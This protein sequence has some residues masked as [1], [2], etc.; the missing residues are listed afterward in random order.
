MPLSL[1]G[2][3][4]L[5]LAAVLVVAGIALA[6]VV[7]WSHIQ[8]L[9]F[10]FHAA[11][12]LHSAQLARSYYVLASDG[13][14]EW[15]KQISRV[16]LRED[17]PIELPIVQYS[18]ATAYR[19]LGG[20]RLWIPRLL[21]SLFWIAGGALIY[22]LATRLAPWWA[23]V[24]AVALYLFLP[25]PLVASTSFQPDPL[26]VTLLVAAALAIVR[27]D[28]RTTDGRFLA[29]VALS[30]AAIFVKPGI[31]AFFLL[32]LFAAIS[33]ARTG[34]R[35]TFAPAR[36]YAF[37][38]LSV[39]PTIAFYVYAAAT[40]QFVTGRLEL[41]VNPGLLA[42]S[43]FWQDWRAMVESVLRPPFFGGWLSLVL[44][45]VALCALLVARSRRN[46]AVLLGLWGGYSLF[47]L[48]ITNYV[49]THDYYSLPLVP[50]A[51]LSLAAVAAAAGER[52]RRPLRRSAVQ[53]GLATV[54]V[55]LMGGVA[56]AKRDA[57]GLPPVDRASERRIEVYEHV[58]E[59]VNHTSRA[60]VLGGT[61]LW[62]YAWIAGRYWPEEA[63]LEWEQTYNGLRAMEAD[64]RFV[65]TDER[66]YPAVGTM[67]PRPS[68]FIVGEPIE[69]ALQPDLS[70][71]LSDYPVLAETPDY[72]I[73]DLT[74]M[75]GSTPATAIE[76]ANDGFRASEMSSFYRFPP[77]WKG[78]D[79][80]ATRAEVLNVVGAPRRKAIRRDLRKPVEAW[81]YGAT[82]DYAIVFVDGD[83][84]AKAHNRR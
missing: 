61:G 38:L 6:L 26:M 2:R 29:A 10:D 28:E 9:P 77:A 43:F 36:V 56:Y 52:L 31:A 64:E 25:F 62:H 11:R 3:S 84:F 20:E 13:M 16:R 67:R 82:D 78:I 66:Y 34:V 22:F 17:A 68:V 50:I 40:E 8:A 32:P 70:V 69:L 19:F 15:K 74:H 41:S 46:R 44:L 35:R 75:L 60:L 73:F 55:L 45:V 23:A 47:G 63:D 51:A 72:V 7:R 4:H 49:S 33:I 12:Q 39:V 48:T 24:G 14:P 53:A 27:Y 21:S 58:G 79:R 37:S 5:L 42:E 76:A 59:I 83:V 81:F 18:A 65:T 54:L 71:L 1:R 80:G 57:L 30:A